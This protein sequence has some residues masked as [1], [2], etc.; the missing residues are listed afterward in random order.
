MF[1]VMMVFI[2]KFNCVSDILKNVFV[3]IKIKWGVGNY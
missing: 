2:S 3:V 1:G